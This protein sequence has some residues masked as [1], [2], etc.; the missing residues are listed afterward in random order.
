MAILPE[1]VDLVRRF[2]PILYFN[3]LNPFF[4]SD[5]KRYV[6]HCALWRA[7]VPF[8]AKDSW[9][10]A[11]GTPFPR[12]PRIAHGKIGGRCPRPTTR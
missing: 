5:A 3:R 1:H 12:T 8:D 7:V 11:P 6:E 2:E 4:P 10:A 9:G